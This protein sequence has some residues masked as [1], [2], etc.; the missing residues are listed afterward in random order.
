MLS[1]QCCCFPSSILFSYIKM[2]VKVGHNTILCKR[3]KL[4]A[5][6]ISNNKW[7]IKLWHIHIVNIRLAFKN[8]IEMYLL[9]QNDV[10]DKSLSPRSDFTSNHAQH[11]PFFVYICIHTHRKIHGK[12]DSKILRWL[13]ISET[14]NF[15]TCIIFGFLYWICIVFG[16]SQKK[17]K[18]HG[19]ISFKV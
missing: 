14:M 7:F 11:Y 10:Y 18:I 4:N 1:N 6:K 12:T 8:V 17:K 3:E 16:I 9:L 19:N 2:M 15:S 13:S 5:K